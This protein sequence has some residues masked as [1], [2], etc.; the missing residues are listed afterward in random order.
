MIEPGLAVAD[1]V[2]VVTEQRKA[3]GEEGVEFTQCLLASD[4]PTKSVGAA[5]SVGELRSDVALRF[6]ERLGVL[7]DGQLGCAMAFRQSLAVLGVEAPLATDGFA[8][9]FDEDAETLALRLV[10]VDHEGL[11]LSSELLLDEAQWREKHWRVMHD[12]LERTLRGEAPQ[13]TREHVIDGIADVQRGDALRHQRIEHRERGRWLAG[14]LA[15]NDLEALGAALLHPVRHARAM[16]HELLRMEPQR[17]VL[18]ITKEQ[19][20]LQQQHLA[21]ALHSRM[22]NEELMREDEAEFH[23]QEIAAS[24]IGPRVV[25]GCAAWPCWVHLN[26][27]ASHI[28]AATRRTSGISG[29]QSVASA[30]AVSLGQKVLAPRSA[31][32][33]RSASAMASSLIMAWRCV[34]IVRCK[35]SPAPSRAPTSCARRM[36]AGMRGRSWWG[37]VVF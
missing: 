32:M 29:R 33:P 6:V 20:V 27:P 2:L 19:G 30:R 35:T 3:L 4:R 26:S 12:E 34:C 14:C 8:V 7:K 10:E 21:A 17:P 36:V 16:Q 5:A 28:A 31:A 1:R 22:R 18:V 13:S 37:G 24:R 25:R 23:D 11:L 15:A 9:G